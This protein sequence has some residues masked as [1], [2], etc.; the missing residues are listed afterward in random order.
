MKDKEN[1]EDVIYT[2]SELADSYVNKDIETMDEWMSMM[3]DEELAVF[4]RMWNKEPLSRSEEENYEISKFSLILYCREL[5]LKE[6]AVTPELMGKITGYFGINIIV[7]S[8][9]RK[10]LAETEGPLLLY[11]ETKITLTGK[12]KEYLED[13]TSEE[14]DEEN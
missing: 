8:L 12:G 1:N 2:L 6:L 11:K 7:E 3:S 13:N 10:G 5:G 9:R 4:H 14:S